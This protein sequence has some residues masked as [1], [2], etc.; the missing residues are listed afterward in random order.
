MLV[1]ATGVITGALTAPTA[2]FAATVKTD[3]VRA[4][5]MINVRALASS[6][7]RRVNGLKGGMTVKITCQLV[8]ELVRGPLRNTK[9]WDHLAI[10]GYVSDALIAH[11]LK[12]APIPRCVAP[13]SAADSIPP[14]KDGISTTSATF[15][16]SIA[17]GARRGFRE[18]QVPASVTMAQAILESGW[19]K[20]KLTAND[21]NYFGIKCFGSPGEIAVSCHTYVTKEC[22]KAG[23]CYSTTAVFRAYRSAADSFRDHALFLAERSRYAA[24]FKYSTVPDKFA[25]E[26]H[27]AGYATDPQY[28]TKLIGLMKS[29][30]LYRYDR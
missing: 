14:A 16:T 18:Y 24:A 15:L 11:P 20:S 26:I 7:S 12:R 8:G 27:K 25:A 30:D 6:G 4:G 3:Q 22:T 23:V 9:M 19:G 13:A 28:T 1:I 10:G 21:K 5:G 17:G 2:A 29:Y